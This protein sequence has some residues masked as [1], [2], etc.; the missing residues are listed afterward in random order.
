MNLEES[1]LE[2]LLTK[3][4]EAGW[5]GSKDLAPEA[6]S[7]IIADLKDE[8]KPSSDPSKKKRA[9]KVPMSAAQRTLN[10]F[11]RRYSADTLARLVMQDSSQGEAYR[12]AL[13]NRNNDV[14]YRG[15]RVDRARPVRRQ[16]EFADMYNSYRHASNSGNAIPRT[17]EEPVV[18]PPISAEAINDILSWLPSED[19]AAEYL[20]IT[21]PETTNQVNPCMEINLD[22]QS[23][24]HPGSSTRIDG[25]V[26]TYFDTYEDGNGDGEPVENANGEINSTQ[27][28]IEE[29]T[30]EEV[31]HMLNHWHQ[32]DN[33]GP[34]E[35]IE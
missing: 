35:T 12:V 24:F 17:S 18:L 3:A 6:V 32:I 26:P 15:N 27:A 25:S 4:Y 8:Q 20:A 16:S 19:S 23:V 7:K 31:D 30:T 28:T 14:E 2:K 10:D 5:Y 1:K 33:D 9:K 21:E 13:L 34:D 11:H 29:L 22:G